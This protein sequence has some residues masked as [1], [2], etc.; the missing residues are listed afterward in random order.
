VS[1]DLRMLLLVLKVRPLFKLLNKFV[2]E[3]ERAVR[4]IFTKARAGAPCIVFFVSVLCIPLLS[5]IS[6]V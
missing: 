1:S 5:L 2:G 3:S 6:L 4:E